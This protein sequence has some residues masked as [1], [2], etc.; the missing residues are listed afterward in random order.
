MDDKLIYSLYRAAQWLGFPFIVLYFLGRGLRD[1]RYFRRFGERL[2][3]IAHS[4]KRP[5]PGAIWIHAVSVGEVLSAPGLL[6]GLRRSFPTA[7]LFV[8]TTTLAGRALADEKLASVVCGVFY[9]PIDYCFAVRR[10]LR[11]IR[12]AVVVVLET[13]I[14]PNLYRE[15]KRAG[16]TLIVVNGRISDRAAPRYHR[17]RWFFRPVLRQAD[18]ILVQTE[19]SLRRYLELGA[20]AVLGGNLKYDFEPP[21][22]GAAPEVRKALDRLKPGSIWIAASTM[23]PAEPGDPDEDDSVIAAFC[24]LAPSRPRL[25]LIH[26]PRRPERFDSAAEKLTAAGV[27]FVRRTALADQ[28]PLPA[29][30]CVLLLDSIGELSA[31]F[32]H[33]DVVF[34]GGTLPHRGGHN[35]LE[36]AFFARP[37]VIGPHMENF[38]EIAAEFIEAEACVR[39]DSPLE[40]AAAVDTLLSDPDRR[41]LLGERARKLAEARRGATDRAVRE[42]EQLRSRA[43]PVY[44]PAFP[45]Y[46]ILWL[47]SG[48]W[49]LGGLAKRAID[50]AR[51]RRLSTP[52]MSVGSITMGGSGKTPFVLWLAERL[53]DSGL[54]PAILTRGYRRRVPEKHTILGPGD[55]VSPA[56]TGDE[57]QI[58]LRSGVGPVGIGAGRAAVGRLV[59]ER[60]RPDVMLLDDGFQHWRLARDLDIVLIDALAPFG[61]NQHLFPLGRLREPMGALSR[62]AA[63]VMTRT[64]PGRGYDAIVDR[65]REYNR[66]A[67]VF[68]SRVVPKSWVEAGTVGQFDPRGLPHTRL[69]AFCGLANPSSYWSTLTALEIEPLARWTFGDHHTYKP[70]DL[71]RLTTQARTAGIEALLT[72]EKDAMNISEGA[73]ALLSPLKLYWLDITVE[74]DGAIEL[75]SLI[76]SKLFRAS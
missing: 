61:P 48:L 53:K 36:P 33:A 30:P 39:I 43:L 69:G 22:G 63:F 7:P 46:Q 75:L 71:R 6:Q 64:E 38:P 54:S 68:F 2:G 73:L 14:W 58:F 8:S 5:A 31:L 10:V 12:P 60:F 66:A 50:T 76:R 67:P 24:E 19:V 70:V 25:L 9:A 32:A 51:R 4:C 57:A 65:L 11:T 44:R 29:L 45:L 56:R 21:S 49:W 23:P 1:R 27:P 40:L 26:V 3:F 37:V 52:V 55:Q 20:P 15:A 35:I 59:E 62:A 42:I 17:L 34:M 72:T 74:V 18:R 47:L 41:S 16:C 28:P 13:E